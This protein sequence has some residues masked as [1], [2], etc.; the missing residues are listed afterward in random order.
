MTKQKL[1]IKE[2]KRKRKIK[3]HHYPFFFFQK[4]KNQL[5]TFGLDH[6][7]CKIKLW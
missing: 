6:S 1:M 5:L 7:K 4:Q 3:K 2:V